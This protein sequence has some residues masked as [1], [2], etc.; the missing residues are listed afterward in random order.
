MDNLIYSR[1]ELAIRYGSAS[2]ERNRG[3]VFFNLEQRPEPG[4]VKNNHMTASSTKI[5][6]ADK[7]GIEG[8]RG[9]TPVEASDFN[10]SEKNF[11]KRTHTLI[12]SV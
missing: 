1:V 6:S 2:S 5:S 7:K 3:S 4:F 12:T 11:E 9:Q 8:T 10:V